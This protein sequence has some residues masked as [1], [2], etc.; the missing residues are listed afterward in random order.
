M[1]SVD[2]MQLFG[3]LHEITGCILKDCVFYGME[4][5]SKILVSIFTVTVI[6]LLRLAQTCSFHLDILGDDDV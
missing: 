5:A 6:W 1:D 2:F 4:A 3:I